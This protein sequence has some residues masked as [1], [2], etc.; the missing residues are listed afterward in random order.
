M[1]SGGPVME[2][3]K[4]LGE[5]PK[6]TLIFVGYQGEGTLGRRIQKGWREIQVTNNGKQSILKLEMEIQTIDG[7]SGHSD[8]TQLLNFVSRLQ[9][10]PERIIT[11]HGDNTNPVNL[12]RSLHKFF[13]VETI[14]PKNLESIRLK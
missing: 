1:L 12:A 2:H 3:I 4:A 7:L 9:S 11:C 14:S 6:N 13:G 8:R 10:K 5:D